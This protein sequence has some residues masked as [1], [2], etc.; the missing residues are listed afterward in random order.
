MMPNLNLS[1]SELTALLRDVCKVTY[2]QDHDYVQIADT[3]VWMEVQGHSGLTTVLANHKTLKSCPFSDHNTNGVVQWD[4]QNNSLIP[5]AYMIGDMMLARAVPGSRFV[6]DN[7][8]NISALFPEMARLAHAGINNCLM[9]DGHLIAESTKDGLTQF[10]DL[11]EDSTS[12]AWVMSMAEP[13]G[14]PLKNPSKFSQRNKMALLKGIPITR[15]TYLALSLCA[16]ETLV[17]ASEQSR[18]GAGD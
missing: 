8:T 7:G 1:F 14:E 5:M 13:Q 6:I 15:D 16:S 4:L 2:G 12:L 3:L 11:S 9:K 10:V 18:R 17:P